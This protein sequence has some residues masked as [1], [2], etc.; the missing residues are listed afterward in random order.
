MSGTDWSVF[1]PPPGRFPKGDGPFG[2]SDLVGL[3]FNYTSTLSGT[4]GDDPQ[5]R[6]SMLSRSG[7]WQGHE[8][9][10]YPFGEGPYGWRTTSKYWATGARCAR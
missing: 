7:S 2:H 5:T 3:V 9:P 1:I 8:A 4:N 10:Y 6:L